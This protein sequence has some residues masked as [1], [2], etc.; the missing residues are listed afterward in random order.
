MKQK[1]Q[2]GSTATTRCSASME[3]ATRKTLTVQRTQRVFG[4]RTKGYR[5]DGC[6]KIFHWDSDC[7]WYGSYFDLENC[8]YH[9]I[10]FACSQACASL[11][12]K[13]FPNNTD[14]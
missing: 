5:C 8:E 6:K 11:K 1:T 12:P 10:W 3:R 2:C 4:A 14:A 9:K 7:Q 13:N